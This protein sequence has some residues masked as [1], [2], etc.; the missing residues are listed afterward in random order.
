MLLKEQSD[1][2]LHCLHMH[3]IRNF[4]VQNLGHLQYFYGIFICPHLWGGGH[5]DFGADPVGIDICTISC[6]LVVG[7]YQIF[8]DV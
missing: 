3:F 5:I 4:G 7:F 1:L 6:E 2:D 8:M